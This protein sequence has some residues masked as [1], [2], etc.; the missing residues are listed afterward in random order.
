MMLLADNAARTDT[1]LTHAITT[2]DGHQGRL[3][4]SSLQIQWYRNMQNIQNTKVLKY[5]TQKEYEYDKC[6]PGVWDLG[7][8]T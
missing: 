1:T 8:P 2:Q 5:K 4:P 7:L 3:L 6:M